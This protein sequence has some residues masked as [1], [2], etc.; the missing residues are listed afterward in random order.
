MHWEVL[1]TLLQYLTEVFKIQKDV[2]C[3]H[4]NTNYGVHTLL[5]KEKKRKDRSF[6]TVCN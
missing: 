5:P 1:E 2:F 3:P 4:F 6:N